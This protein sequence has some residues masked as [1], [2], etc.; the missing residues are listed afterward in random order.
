M[1]YKGIFQI[2]DTLEYVLV[3]NVHFPEQIYYFSVHI[4]DFFG[5]IY[6]E[7]GVQNQ[8][9]W[10]Y[11]PGPTNLLFAASLSLLFIL[12][13]EGSPLKITLLLKLFIQTYFSNR[14]L[15]K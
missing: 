10:L 6:F 15:I 4:Y 1:S 2:P 14:L 7:F 11:G 13:G 12:Y 3:L 5:Y 8:F 9:L